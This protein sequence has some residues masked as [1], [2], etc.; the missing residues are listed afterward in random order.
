MYLSLSP[1]YLSN[2]K[3]IC[4]M[5]SFWNIVCLSYLFVFPVNFK[6]QSSEQSSDGVLRKNEKGVLEIEIDKAV[7]PYSSSHAI[8]CIILL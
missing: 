1:S 5:I 4:L 6:P 3:I 2:S 8:Y 7:C